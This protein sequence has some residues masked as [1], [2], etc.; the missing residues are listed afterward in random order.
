MHAELQNKFFTPQIVIILPSPPDG[1]TS[2]RQHYS[3]YSAVHV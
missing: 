2:L 1:I 3:T